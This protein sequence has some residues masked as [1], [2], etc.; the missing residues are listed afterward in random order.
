MIELKVNVHNC[1][2]KLNRTSK[3]KLYLHNKYREK[4]KQSFDIVSVFVI[5]KFLMEALKMEM[6]AL[7]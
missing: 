5:L 4:H 7:Q 1:S 6:D 3:Q 2:T